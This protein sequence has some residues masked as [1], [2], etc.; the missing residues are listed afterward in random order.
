[1]R[2]ATDIGGTFT[3]IVYIDEQGKVC[4]NKS[5]TTPPDFE[6][7]VLNVIQKCDISP[8]EVKDLSHG[9]TVVINAL[10]ERTGAK[11][12]LITT[13]GFRD[14]LEI[15]RGN[16]PDLFNFNFKKPKP[17]VPRYLRLEVE[18]R[19]D[20]QGNELIALKEEDIKTCVD[21]FKK[22]G[23][24]A[25]AIVFLHSYINA[26]HE[27]QAKALVEKLMPGIAVTA[28]HEVSKEWREY[29]RTTTA[30]LNSYVKPSAK[31]YIDNLYNKLEEMDIKC[32]KYI[33][34]SNGGTTTFENAKEVP[35]NMVESGP[36]AGI[37]GSA[38]LGEMLGENKVIAFD[39]G[40]TTAKCSLVDG[41]E[42]KTT[43]EYKIE[44]NA[45]FPG[46]P[47]RVPVVDIVEIGNGGGSIA[48]IDNTNSLRVGPK[49]AGALPGPV[50][51]QKGG[52]EPT[53]TDANLIAGRLSPKN[54][55]MDVDMEKVRGAIQEK[56]GDVYG[57]NTEEAAMGIIRVANSNMLNA[58]K[59][60][61]ISKGYDPREF[62]LVAFGG[63][64]PMHAA[65]LAKELNIKKVII[66]LAASVFSA[67][68]MLMTDLRS[69]DIQTYR[70]KL[71]NPDF[72]A[73]NAEWEGLEEKACQD[74]ARKGISRED[75][76][77]QHYLDMRYIGQDHTVKVKV[78]NDPM[79]AENISE[80]IEAFHREHE[81][82]YSF[83][84]D[85]SGVE[86]VNIHLASFGRIEKTPI[87]EAEILP[88]S[89]EEAIKEIRPVIFE[90]DGTLD[91]KVYDREKMS[92]G[93]KL[94]GPAIIEEV[95]SS[96]VIY[97]GMKA[98]VDKFGDILIETG[99]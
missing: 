43:T 96:A 39:I 11:T 53:T 55:D 38:M 67:W 75:V 97:P 14:I 35:I 17:F 7:G 41:G 22:E 20:Y 56:V 83:R 32:P 54:F 69:D 48:W 26:E 91:T 95:S 60:V 98:S 59:L 16:R 52:T 70:V 84:L 99:V 45:R 73:I 5:H 6:Q 93:M 42:V 80:F 28:S 64:G 24:E 85:E 46:Y 86:I 49:S 23:V 30:V 18:E 1:M 8:E 33:M 92:P 12:G 29:E 27:K 4:V 61:S 37:Y 74:N 34:Q 31:T 13:K 50:A 87:K 15:G 76:Y 57:I 68:G 25:I 66:P 94:E 10:T 82:N 79:S 89:L 19:M 40:G 63:G 65:A 72:D 58:L 62:A 51:Y 90:G 81:Q 21:T 47:I 88:Y 3:D 2:V 44:K 71:D 77:F 36:V 9:T 78:P